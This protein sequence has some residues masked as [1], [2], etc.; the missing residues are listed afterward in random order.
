MILLT[1]PQGS[2]AWHLARLGIPTASQ[3]SRILTPKTRK[4]GS[5]AETYMLELLAEWIIGIPGGD[6]ARGYMERGRDLESWAV[7]YYELVRGVTTTPAGVCLRDDRMVACSPDR[8][9]GDDGGMEIK[10]PS[11]KVHVA[12]LLGLG[13][14]HVGQVQGN[15]WITGRKW[16]DLVSYHP[17]IPPTIVRV[18]RD[19][20]Y[21]A[22]LEA[23]MGEF[24][25]RLLEA[26]RTLIA[27]GVESAKELDP[28]FAA[29]LPPEPAR[30]PVSV[31]SCAPEDPLARSHS[32]T[33]REQWVD[34]GPF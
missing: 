10:V 8:L 4:L 33:P 15:L 2:A 18:E 3:F 26:R 22:A 14:D 9:V 20:G 29:T 25:P 17:E 6:D 32:V 27:Q 28:D 13:D 5:G 7:G 16:W 24:I 21:I 19:E 31:A 11:A 1:M 23:G 30:E 34:D 12:N